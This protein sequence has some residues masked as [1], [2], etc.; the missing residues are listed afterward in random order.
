VKKNIL[1]EE[2]LK[3]LCEQFGAELPSPVAASE[4]SEDE[5]SPDNFPIF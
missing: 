5:E 2:K 1:L 3:K 4:Q